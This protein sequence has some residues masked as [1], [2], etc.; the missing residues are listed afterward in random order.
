V[1][2]SGEHE[3]EQNPL[4]DVLFNFTDFHV[5][6][7]LQPLDADNDDIS[8]DNHQTEGVQ[9]DNILVT[10]LFS[11]RNKFACNL[12]YYDAVLTETDA[13]RLMEV[14]K[15][16]LHKIAW[17]EEEP[18]TKLSLM[19]PSEWELINRFEIRDYPLAS[20]LPALFSLQA[21]SSGNEVALVDAQGSMRF[22][23]LEQASD[24]LAGYLQLRGIQ[25]GEFVCLYAGR[26]L[27][28]IV[29]MLAVLKCGAA[30]VPVPTD[31]PAK[32]VAYIIEDSGARFVITEPALAAGLST[33]MEYINID[34]QANGGDAVL[35]RPSFSSDAA[36]YMIYTSGSTGAPKGVVISHRSVGNLVY[37]LHDQ[38]YSR[39]K[40]R[41]QLGLLSGFHFDASVQHIYSA[42]LLG[43]TVHIAT[44]ESRADGVALVG[45]Y[46][47]HGITISDGTPTHL[48][49][50]LDASERLPSQLKHFLIAGEALPMA[51]ARRF[52]RQNPTGVQ[53]SNL[54]GPTETCVDSTCFHVEAGLLDAYET[55]PIGRPLPNEKVYILSQDHQLQ[56][57]GVPG[58][59]YISGEGLSKGYH[60]QPSLTAE[61][62]VMHPHITGEPL[63]RTGDVGKWLPDGNIS[64]IG[65]NDDQVKIKGFRIHLS[66]IE[67]TLL[68]HPRVQEALAI[69]AGSE[70]LYI[71][72]YVINKDEVTE[73][74]LKQFLQHALPQ[75]ML[76]RHII[77]VNEWPR[78]PSGKID[79]K[80]LPDA[81]AGRESQPVVAASDT[82]QLQL[83][84]I[85]EELLKT[86]PISIQDDFFAL[87][88]DSIK[89]IKLA[90]WVQ[91][92][93][94]VSFKVHQFYEN[95]T[96]EKLA[97]LL[98]SAT[99]DA[100][101]S[102]EKAGQELETFKSNFIN[103]L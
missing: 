83:I 27:Q 100:E 8:I 95:S 11:V 59:I 92:N 76:P 84:A 34:W 32:R 80:M 74:E 91:N 87:G 6:D 99:I 41:Q 65:R 77:T 22:A 86:K 70:E 58:E 30:Y 25:P 16:V 56:G 101:N 69:T 44:E 49:L 17:C 51:L 81:N 90:H 48:Q 88:G 31:L 28:I 20:T 66:E 82:L 42:L 57:P 102:R 46:E 21:G 75:Y 23:E 14:Y 98:R 93:I 12:L 73:K 1:K 67:H 78:T 45:F 68:Q 85:W 33:G 64:F 53:L 19:R 50:I 62:F 52:Y 89:L 18:A 29:A 13:G 103:N 15:A 43:H 96:V 5:Y 2:L 26:S 94:G 35:N 71:C 10:F 37:G 7:M 9:K 3:Q 4:F 54:Y 55:V 79:R 72:V 97:T 36:A 40:G 61:R 38:I 39:Y 60:N 24:Q 47:R 63:Y